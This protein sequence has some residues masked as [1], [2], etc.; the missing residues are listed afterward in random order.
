MAPVHTYTH[1]NVYIYSVFKKGGLV[2]NYSFGTARGRLLT[3]MNERAEL[4]AKV[5]HPFAGGLSI[6]TVFIF[7]EQDCI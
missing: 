2:D 3:L 6:G 4:L 1:I 5:P 7:V